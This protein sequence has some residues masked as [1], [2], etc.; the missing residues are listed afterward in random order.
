MIRKFYDERG[1]VWAMQVSDSAPQDALGLFLGP[2]DLA[3]LRLMPETEQHL[4]EKLVEHEL[5]FA[6][7]LM[8][9]RVLLF[10]ILHDVG[11]PRET[12]RPLV[13]LY[14]SDYYGDG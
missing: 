9:Q 7:L 2:P 1:M 10:E 5:Y 12:I 3:S 11:L 6:P 8:G 13:A 4:R 14:Q